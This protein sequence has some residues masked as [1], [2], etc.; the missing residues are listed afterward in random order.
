MSSPRSRRAKAVRAAAV[1]G[2]VLGLAF[3]AY[4]YSM[5]TPVRFVDVRDSFEAA[6]LSR[7]WDTK[8]VVPGELTLQSDVARAGRRAVKIMIHHGDRFE[9][10]V[11]GHADTERTE[12][13]EADRLVSREGVAY[14][15]AFS[16]MI[17]ADFPITPTR[18]VIAQ[19]KQDCDGHPP[20]SD[21]S[22]VFALRYMSG[23]LRITDRSKVTL[24]E[25]SEERR[26]RWTD[27][28]FQIR[29]TP[30]PD[31]RFRAWI[32]GRQ[33]L[34]YRGVTAYPEN[35]ATGYPNPSLFYFKM[36]LYRDV[37]AEPMTLYIDEYR[38][39]QLPP[40]ALT[41]RCDRR[42]PATA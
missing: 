9:A 42:S 26:G 40:E 16:M 29:F 35:A 3:A 2:P 20:C 8:R 23:V 27:F 11:N 10:G 24:Y 33:A 17:P 22:P 34:D 39:R 14:E 38:K 28:R 21:D 7:F 25:S 1:A 12:M 15:Y 4:Q 5:R 6:S 36:G 19:W 13:A 32:D 31:G 41:S 18:L 30:R 37:M